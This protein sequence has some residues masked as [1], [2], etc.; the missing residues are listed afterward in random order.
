MAH[1]SARP[2]SDR[3]GGLRLGAARRWTDRGDLA[4]RETLA[5][6]HADHCHDAHRYSGKEGSEGGRLDG[7]GYQRAIP[8]VIRW[9]SSTCEG[10]NNA[11]RYR[12][13][14]AWEI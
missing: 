3:H 6:R 14:L 12:Q 13:A 9:R 2:D 7:A 10:V 8:Q 1:S 5:W 11:S 4:R